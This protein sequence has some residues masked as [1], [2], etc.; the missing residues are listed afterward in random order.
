[1]GFLKQIKNEIKIILSSKFI[2][3]FVILALAGSIAAPVISALQPDNKNGGYYPGPMPMM[4]A[5][6]EK[7]MYGGGYY[8]EGQDPIQ[9]GDTTITF[10]NPL[11]GNLSS[12]LYEKEY[13]QSYTGYSEEGSMLT[14]PEA[15]DLAL[16]LLD[17][18]FEY[19]GRFAVS[20]STYE[21]Y[22]FQLIWIGTSALY[23]Q[24]VYSRADTEDHAVLKEA[25]QYRL[26]LDS[27]QF[28]KKYYDI[29]AVDRLAALDEAESTLNQLYDIVD[30]NN[31]ST[32]IDLMIS[33]QNVQI[34]DLNDMIKSAEE[35]IALH[36]ELEES[37]SV[38]IQRYR[39]NIELIQT[40]TIYWLE[41]RRENTIIPG[42]GVWQDTAINDISNNENNLKNYY[43]ITEEQFSQDI[44]TAQQYG[45][46]EKY[47]AF[48]EKQKNE[49]REDIQIGRNCLD[50]DQP[51]MKYIPDGARFAT[52]GFLV[53]S[54]AIA[55]IAVLLGGWL[56]ASEFQSGTVRL[57][58]IRPKTRTKILMSK[59]FG[60]LIILLALYLACA[61]INMLLNGILLGFS[62]YAY[63]NMTV[64]GGVGFFFSYLPGFFA[65]G[66]TIIFA[67][68]AAFMMSVLTRHIA[69]A[70]IVPII[71]YVGCFIATYLPA[72]YGVYSF[73]KWLAWTPIPYVQISNFFMPVAASN[74]GYYGYGVAS[75]FNPVQI[76]MQMGMPLSLAYGIILLLVLSAGFVLI[77]LLTF[78][79]RDITN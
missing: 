73:G 21:D 57:L 40:S 8:G 69:V 70:I 39:D 59:F 48:T 29:S 51:D 66:V 72:L 49:Y 63:P 11:Y 53:Y 71:C 47:I 79:K 37:L 58:M 22:R 2:L 16:E 17:A 56:V 52:S 30:S 25:A 60:A 50:T 77:S 55:I 1:M 62:D 4:G 34:D 64:S 76:M 5:Y 78:R 68:C 44:Y 54:V 7:A 65:C 18:E 61:L 12:I 9:V 14:T 41:Y 42:S 74:Y 28:D 10:E 67:F 3:I 38:E 26:Y 33:Q 46:Y 20:I 45:T 6:A 23:D 15:V 27:D 43:V 13:L 36:P 35:Q 24:F 32:Y 31:F 75:G 19:Y